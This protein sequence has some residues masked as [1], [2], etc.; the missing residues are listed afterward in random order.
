MNILIKSD[1]FSKN[2]VNYLETKPNMM[3][4][5]LFTKMNYCDDFM[6]MYGVYLDIPIQVIENNM[7]P[8]ISSA[9]FAVF[10]SIEHDILSGYLEYRRIKGNAICTKLSEYIQTKYDVCESCSGESLAILKISG[11]WE[12]AIGEVGLSFKV[13]KA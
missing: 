10:Q 9:S 13:V 5:G 6:V 3:F 8:I 12:N 7:K 4:D 11:I 1:N 2:S